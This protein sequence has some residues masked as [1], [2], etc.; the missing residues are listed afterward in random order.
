MVGAHRRVKAADLIATSNAT[1]P[2]GR[3]SSTSCPRKRRSTASR[4]LSSRWR[5]SSYT[6][7]AFFIRHR[8]SALAAAV[9]RRLPRSQFA[10]PMPAEGS[11]SVRTPPR[12]LAMRCRALRRRCSLVI[13]SLTSAFPSTTILSCCMSSALEVLSTARGFAVARRHRCPALDHFACAAGP[14]CGGDVPVDS[15]ADCASWQFASPYALLW[16]NR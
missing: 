7:P 14:D 1:S 5:S 3:R 10:S 11:R 15:R 9:V 13:A 8:R 16:Q 6:T 2:N 12:P 4:V